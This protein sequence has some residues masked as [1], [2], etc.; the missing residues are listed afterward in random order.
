[1]PVPLK[2]I[3]WKKSGGF[4]TYICRHFIRFCVCVQMWMWAQAEDL[5][6]RYGNRGLRLSNAN[7]KPTPSALLCI[8]LQWPQPCRAHIFASICMEMRGNHANVCS[9]SSNM[10]MVPMSS[11]RSLTF[12]LFLTPFGLLCLFW[13]GTGMFLIM[14]KNIRKTSPVHSSELLLQCAGRKSSALSPSFTDSTL[15]TSLSSFRSQGLKDSIS[16]L[17]TSQWLKWGFCS[18]ATLPFTNAPA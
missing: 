4:L 11:T 15:E 10:L 17:C 9:V 12:H 2:V 3:S 6:N 16:K 7:L 8:W 1:M 14:R 5:S 18:A 13:P